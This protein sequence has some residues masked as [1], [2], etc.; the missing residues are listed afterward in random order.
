MGP[1]R[2]SLLQ[3]ARRAP[4]GPALTSAPRR[5][6]GTPWEFAG[7]GSGLTFFVLFA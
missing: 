3:D 4:A 1:F 7:A 5:A 2:V 6:R